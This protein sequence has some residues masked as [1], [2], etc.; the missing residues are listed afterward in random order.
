[1]L[2]SG[3]V[4]RNSQSDRLFFKFH[5]IFTT[6]WALLFSYASW[7]HTMNKIFEC[8]F[9][10]AAQHCSNVTCQNAFVKGFCFVIISWFHISVFSWFVWW[11]YHRS[12][13]MSRCYLPTTGSRTACVACSSPIGVLNHIFFSFIAMGESSVDATASRIINGSFVNFVKAIVGSDDWI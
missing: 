8:S 9:Q 4:H 7:L 10:T 5:I 12:R 2:F 13:R 6:K 1:M 11:R 3:F